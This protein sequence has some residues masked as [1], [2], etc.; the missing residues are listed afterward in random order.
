MELALIARSDAAL[1]I[2]ILMAR[3]RAEHVR[4]GPMAEYAVG[5]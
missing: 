3:Q 4:Y 1:V 5:A 2:T